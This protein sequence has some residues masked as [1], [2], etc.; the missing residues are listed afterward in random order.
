MAIQIEALTLK[1]NLKA[2]KSLKDALNDEKSKKMGKHM[3]HWCEHHMAWCMHRPSECHLG[4]QQRKVEQS[5]TAGGNS[6]TYAA[7]AASFANPQFQALI[8]SMQG[9]FNED[10]WCAP[11]R[12]WNLLACVAGPPLLNTGQL[13]I[14]TYLFI[15]LLPIIIISLM[16]S[17]FPDN[18]KALRFLM[19]TILRGTPWPIRG[20]RGPIWRRRR[21]VKVKFKNRNPETTTTTKHWQRAQL[22]A[23]AMTSLKVGCQVESSLRCPHQ[24]H[25]AFAGIKGDSTSGQ[26]HFDSDSFPIRIDNHASYCMANSP[27]LFDDLILSD[28]GKVNGINDG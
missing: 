24:S 6:A 12:I 25:Y 2:D 3:F 22:F 19:V 7:A 27:H 14:I 5:P 23:L 11:A 28:V 10:R 13:N 18:P 15:F 26:V 8:A 16:R 17:V 21:K 9:R 1:G 4:N 20:H